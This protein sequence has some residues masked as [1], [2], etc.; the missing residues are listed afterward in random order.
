M[1]SIAML[2]YLVKEFT[3][4]VQRELPA[5]P[6]LTPGFFPRHTNLSAGEQASEPKTAEMPI[7][8]WLRLSPI[9]VAV[10]YRRV[11]TAVLLARLGA[12]LLHRTDHVAIRRPAHYSV[13][14]YCFKGLTPLHLCALLNLR[15]AATALI[16]EAV[17]DRD[18]VSLTGE[19][20][21]R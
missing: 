12:D 6:D 9:E 7:W 16:H 19:R 2:E 11:D 17:E 15:V 1:G 5:V 8:A 3:L 10:L 18:V 20:A 4:S 13:S 14:N 21:T